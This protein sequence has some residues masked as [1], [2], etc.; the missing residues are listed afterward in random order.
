M[1]A[2]IEFKPLLAVTFDFYK[3]QACGNDFV[4]VDLTREEQAL[5]QERLQ[6]QFWLNQEAMA[7]VCDRRFGV[8]ADG[9]LILLPKKSP[10]GSFYLHYLNAN[11][12][13]GSL[14][15]NG[16]RCASAFAFSKGYFGEVGFG[17]FEA[18]D[19][20]HRVWKSGDQDFRLSMKAPRA[21]NVLEVGVFI[22]TG[23]PHLLV[24]VRDLVNYPVLRE[25]K[26]LREHALFG[27][28]GTNVNFYEVMDTNRLKV[29]TYER[30]VENETLSCGTGAVACSLLY[31]QQKEEW[32]EDQAFEVSVQFRGGLM[33]VGGNY[34]GSHFDNLYLSGPANGTFKG[35]WPG[36]ARAT[37]AWSNES[38]TGA[39]Y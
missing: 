7:L 27:S 18:S 10:E 36:I 3:Y 16:A 8:G 34:N 15:G 24:N 20:M 29:R 30:G 39:T 23:S 22:D 35:L 6:S 11:G 31:I 2:R 28:A 13:E 25:G 38:K 1:F 19:G 26:N 14:C 4:L 12:G 5:T 33:K 9:V 37:Y 32:E 17:D 21:W